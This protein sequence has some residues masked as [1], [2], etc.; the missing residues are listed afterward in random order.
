MDLAGEKTEKATP[1]RKQ[2]ERKKGNVFVSQEVVTVA[3]LLASFYA[4]K[5]LAGTILDSLRSF[6]PF[7]IGLGASM[8]TL[9]FARARQLWLQCTLECIKLALPVLLATVVAAVVGTM[10]QT[11]MLVSL[12]SL[13]FKGERI[14]PLNG[15]KKMFSLR[16]VVELLKSLLKIAIL[17]AVLYNILTDQVFQ[18]PRLMNLSAETILPTAGQ[19]ISDIVLTVGAVFL[20]L[21]AADYLYQWWQYEKNL[22]MTKQEVK[23]EYKQMEGDPQVKGR[24]RSIQQQRAKRRMMQAVPSA[25]V[26]IRNPTHFAVALRYDREKDRAPI[27]VAK[28]QDRIALKIVEI[29]EKNGVHVLEDRPLARALFASIEI[30][31]EI[32]AQFYE[33]VAQILAFVYN[34]KKKDT[35]T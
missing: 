4:L 18:L 8:D 33:P 1:K 25:D 30:G 7:M 27:V 32:P 21:A 14:N 26:V 19:L 16:A 6:L 5:I 22:R 31:Q 3:T 12:Q 11:R 35:I 24:Q 28:G 34:L 20:F 13:K 10:L 15:L 23:D 17:A 2:D 29:A 9:D